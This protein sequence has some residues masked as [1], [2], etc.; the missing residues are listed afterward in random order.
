MQK[1]NS[2]DDAGFEDRGRKFGG[3]YRRRV[4]MFSVMIKS[5]IM[6]AVEIWEKEKRG[7]NTEKVPENS[8]MDGRC[9]L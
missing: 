8:I 6:Y 9:I 7:K 4:M 1:S 5:I 3:N 2:G